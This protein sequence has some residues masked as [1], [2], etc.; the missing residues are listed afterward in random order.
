METAGDIAAM[1]RAMLKFESLKNAQ[2]KKVK[3]PTELDAGVLKL[4]GTYRF[5]E[6]GVVA[7]GAA[8]TLMGQTLLNPPTVEGWHTGKE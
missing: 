2:F 1:P 6:P 4:V 8:T 5:P 3:N 7:F